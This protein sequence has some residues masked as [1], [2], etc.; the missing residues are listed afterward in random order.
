[1]LGS[2]LFRDTQHLVVKLSGLESTNTI[3]KNTDIDIHR[4]Y[5]R[6]EINFWVGFSAWENNFLGAIFLS[7]CPT[8]LYR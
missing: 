5:I 4:Q 6:L 8:S 2:C 3:D 1:M 7:K